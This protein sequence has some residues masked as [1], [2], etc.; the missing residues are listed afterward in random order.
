MEQAIFRCISAIML[1]FSF[2]TIASS[3]VIYGDGFKTQSI[4][5][6][7]LKIS[8]NSH[9]IDF[10]THNTMPVQDFNVVN[11]AMPVEKSLLSTVS[12]NYSPHTAPLFSKLTRSNIPADLLSDKGFEANP[13]NTVWSIRQA[14][15][16]LLY[17][18]M[19]FS[20]QPIYFAIPSHSI[21]SLGFRFWQTIVEH[22]K[23][24]AIIDQN[25][26]SD[27]KP[28]PMPIALLGVS[29][30]SLATLQQRGKYRLL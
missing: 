23:W 30:M 25:L 14:C 24:Q 7:W 9:T 19:H 8:N 4:H 16:D 21:D 6:A 15:D 11:F 20:Q 26:S 22:Q 13:A 29:F 1:F 5:M 10:S 12:T 17:E 28:E 27:S 3:T 2:A 18:K